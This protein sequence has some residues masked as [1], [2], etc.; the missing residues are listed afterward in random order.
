MNILVVN[1]LK[2]FALCIAAWDIKIL[3]ISYNLSSTK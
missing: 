1:L 3:G 2:L